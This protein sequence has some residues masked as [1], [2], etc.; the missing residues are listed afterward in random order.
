LVETE[1]T[2]VCDDFCFNF[3]DIRKI[4]IESKVEL[5]K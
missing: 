4:D 1:N 3:S 2:K 5:P